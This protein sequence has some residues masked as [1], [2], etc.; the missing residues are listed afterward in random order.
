MRIREVRGR[1]IEETGVVK[2]E[3]GR[4]INI[5]ISYRDDYNEFN[6]I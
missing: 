4:R 1:R 6:L 2:E 3:Y 5:S